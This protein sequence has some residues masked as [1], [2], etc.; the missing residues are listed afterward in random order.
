M[1]PEAQLLQVTFSGQTTFGYTPWEGPLIA[2]SGDGVLVQGAP[3][4]TIDCDGKRWWDGK[5]GNGGQKKPK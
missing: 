3:G 1:M 2:V 5:G 4:H